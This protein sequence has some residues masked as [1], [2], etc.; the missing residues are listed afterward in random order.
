[1][2]KKEVSEVLFEKELI[3]KAAAEL[4]MDENKVQHHLNFM[5]DFLEEVMESDEIHSIQLPHLGVMYRNIKTCSH[6]VKYIDAFKPQFQTER[7]QAARR[8]SERDIKYLLGKLKSFENF[9]LHNYRR[10]LSNP[11]FTCI[12]NKE[13]LEK[14][15]N[16]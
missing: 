5:K 1:M 8:K 13:E 3:R 6:M 11:Y 9:S 7:K 12:K 10:R 4:G 2:E 16:D 15:Q 14:F